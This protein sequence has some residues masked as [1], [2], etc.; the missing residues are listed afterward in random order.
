MLD[1]TI[2]SFYYAQVHKEVLLLTKYIFKGLIK[3]SFDLYFVVQ[4]TSKQVE[5]NC[6]HNSFVNLNSIFIVKNEEI[7]IGKLVVQIENSEHSVFTNQ[8]L[9]NLSICIMLKRMNNATHE[10]FYCLLLHFF[11]QN[12]VRGADMVFCY[13]NC[14][15]LL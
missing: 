11:G 12:F 9:E 15:D 7:T 6:A 4:D 14:S 2:A 8:L 10:E 5:N 3:V 1:Y 13:H